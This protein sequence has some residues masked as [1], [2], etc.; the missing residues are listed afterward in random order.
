MP[1]HP[2]DTTDQE[3]DADVR[4]L[5]P[6][7]KPLGEGDADMPAPPLETDNVEIDG[8]CIGERWVPQDDAQLAAFVAIIAMGQAAYAAHI[9]SELVPA[10]PAFSTSELRDEAIVRLTVQEQKQAPRTGYPRWHRDGFIFE[11]IS[12]IAVRLKHGERALLLDPHV[13]ATSQGI[14][15][16][17]I[18]LSNDGERIARVTILED[19]CTEDPRKTFL[20]KVIPAFLEHHRGKR[21]A[22]V[23][24]AATVILRMEGF[25]PGSSATLA[26]A[27]T[28]RER[29]AYRAAFALTEEYDSKTERKRLFKDYNKIDNIDAKQRTGAS[30][31]VDGELRDWFEYTADE[32]ITY[33]NDLPVEEV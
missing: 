30:F 10:A 23:V 13:K 28:N 18:R 26:A 7:Q 19:K 1:N 12:W 27:V 20:G 21:S 4:K 17:M 3:Q 25:D 32:A 29:R 22:E 31:I 16:L 33:L 6:D 24:A 14:D 2:S 9:L 15:G 5:L 8:D 11:A